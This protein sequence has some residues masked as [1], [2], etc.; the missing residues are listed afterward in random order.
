MRAQVEI[1]EDKILFT[2][3]E[4]IDSQNID[5]YISEQVEGWMN[6]FSELHEHKEIEVYY[7]QQKIQ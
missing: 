1:M 6:S 3:N 5:L 2:I 4:N 7:G